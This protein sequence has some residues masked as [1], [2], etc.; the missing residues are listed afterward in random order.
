MLLSFAPMEGISSRIY[1]QTHAR[2]FGGVEEDI[3]LRLASGDI[4]AGADGIEAV[5][6]S[7]R[8]EVGFDS[9]HGGGAGHGSGNARH[10]GEDG[11]HDLRRRLLTNHEIAK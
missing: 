1:R 2:F 4:V 10:A 11:R 8:G 5:K 7:Q 6:Q 9:V 3:R